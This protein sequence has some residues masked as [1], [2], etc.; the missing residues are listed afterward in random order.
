MIRD[1][2]NFLKIWLS[3]LVTAIAINY[4]IL[5]FFDIVHTINQFVIWLQ[6]SNIDIYINQFLKG[7]F[8]R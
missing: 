8:G 5:G 3:G 2:K 7:I 6:K 1:I 4:L